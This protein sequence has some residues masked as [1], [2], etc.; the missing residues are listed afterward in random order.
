MGAVVA[1]HLEGGGG[2]AWIPLT[3]TEGCKI[4]D[5]IKKYVYIKIALVMPLAAAWGEA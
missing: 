3:T 2:A 5:E 1:E 4:S